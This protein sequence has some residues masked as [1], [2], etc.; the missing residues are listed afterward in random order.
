MY[1]ETPNLEYQAKNPAPSSPPLVFSFFASLASLHHPN[2]NG[3]RSAKLPSH[4]GVMRLAPV[5]YQTAVCFYSEQKFGLRQESWLFAIL[6]WNKTEFSQLVKNIWIKNWGYQPNL[7]WIHGFSPDFYLFYWLKMLLF[8]EINLRSNGHLAY[9][10]QDFM[11][12]VGREVAE[13]LLEP[14]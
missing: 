5:Y 8:D 12:K 10:L 1:V 14:F 7:W 3:K 11:E 2:G 9:E 13:E 4:S 6:F